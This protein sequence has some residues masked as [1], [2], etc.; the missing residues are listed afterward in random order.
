VT[1]DGITFR[2]TVAGDRLVGAG[3]GD[4][5]QPEVSATV[6]VVAGETRLKIACRSGERT[7]WAHTEVNGEPAGLQGGRGGC[8]DSGFDPGGT[9]TYSLLDLTEYGDPGD[10]VT[11]TVRLTASQRS[12]QP[13]DDDAAVVGFGLYR[14]TA[15]QERLAGTTFDRLVESG[16]HTY[17]LVADA[18]G[19]G[20]EVTVAGLAGRGLLRFSVVF[21]DEGVRV[22][23]VDYGDDVMRTSRSSAG[24]IISIDPVPGGPDEAT[25]RFRGDDPQD[26]MGLAVFEA[27]D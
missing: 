6:P 17:R 25:L 22:A 16:G 21:G 19:K 10:E 24:G 7:V 1:R 15:P 8:S 23:G 13:L 3:I 5:G 14:S 9:G 27:V 18:E 2:E 4:Q 20:P 11:V 12:G 26:R